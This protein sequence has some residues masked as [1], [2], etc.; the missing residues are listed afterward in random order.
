[1]LISFTSCVKLMIRESALAE[2]KLENRQ[3]KGSKKVEHPS[4]L[5]T[6]IFTNALISR[7]IHTIICIENTES[8]IATENGGGQGGG[9][10][11]PCKQPRKKSHSWMPW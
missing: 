4:G 2:R 9:M 7:A 5:G 6:I 3:R 11:V 10:A 8:D 1:V